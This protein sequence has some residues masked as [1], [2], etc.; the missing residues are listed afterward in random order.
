MGV[1]TRVL[2]FFFNLHG[3]GAP[4]R[5]GRWNLDS[6]EFQHK[7]HTIPS[8]S[9][10]PERKGTFEPTGRRFR[11]TNSALSEPVANRGGQTE[12]IRHPPQCNDDG[13]HTRTK[14]FH[15]PQRNRSACERSSVLVSGRRTERAMR[16]RAARCW[17]GGRR[18]VASFGMQGLQ[19]HQQPQSLVVLDSRAADALATTGDFLLGARAAS[20]F[21]AT[22][23]FFCWSCGLQMHLQ[24]TVRFFFAGVVS[25][26]C[27]YSHRCFA[28]LWSKGLQMHLQPQEVCFIVEQRAADA[29]AA[30]GD[31]LLGA[32][33]AS[34][35]AATGAFFCWSCGLQMHV[36][37]QV[38][39]HSRTV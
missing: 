19:M 26:R 6:T 24:P 1:Q 35:F 21:A 18:A 20:A 17:E 31:F 11:W 32:R 25:C 38:P 27:I 12:K 2:S 30:T 29:L 34:A 15:V 16:G 23:A 39:G 9:F 33:A 8:F 4:G 14:P 13:T 22:G 7:P 37:P 3:T 10:R 28:V 36:Q 5:P